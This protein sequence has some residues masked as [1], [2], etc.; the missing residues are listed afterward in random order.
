MWAEMKEW[1]DGEAPSAAVQVC[2]PE[3]GDLQLTSALA[4]SESSQPLAKA[5]K[6]EMSSN[7]PAKPATCV[8]MQRQAVELFVKKSLD[9]YVHQSCG[10][11]T[12][13][14]PNLPNCRGL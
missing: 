1:G 10:N 4:V 6:E 8:K 12:K 3:P 14:C 9:S 13:S 5:D 11:P 2:D 7:N